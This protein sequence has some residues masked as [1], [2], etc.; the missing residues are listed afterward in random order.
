MG[1]VRPYTVLSACLTPIFLDQGRERSIRSVESLLLL[2]Q[3]SC[4]KGLSYSDL[5][6]D[7]TR[8]DATLITSNNRKFENHWLEIKTTTSA[9][10]KSRFEIEL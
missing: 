8:L 7:A 2:W 1:R 9:G 4:P 10:A 6:A 5:H 3:A